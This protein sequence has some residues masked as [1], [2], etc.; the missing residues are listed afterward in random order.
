[1][2]FLLSVVLFFFTFA[3]FAKNHEGSDNRLGSTRQ[4]IP[5]QG[6]DNEACIVEYKKQLELGSYKDVPEC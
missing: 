6:P 4:T 5:S 2:S 1:M 3:S